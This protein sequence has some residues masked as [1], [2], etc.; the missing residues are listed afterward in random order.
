MI[1][2][3]KGTI[4]QRLKDSVVLAVQNLSYEVFLPRTVSERID[5]SLQ[6]NGEI[7]FITYHYLQVD[8]SRSVPVL[9]GF[10]NSYEKDFF[11]LFITVS[12][13]GPKAAIRAL[14]KPISQ[15]AT[16]INEGD[17]AFLKSLPGIGPQ[18]ARQIVAQLQGKMARFGLINDKPVQ[19]LSGE[20]GIHRALKEE[21]VEV[22]RRLQ[23]K[24]P[25]ALAMI[26]RALKENP[27]VD[28]IELLLNEIYTQKTHGTVRA[29]SIN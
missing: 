4:S 10:L 6:E 23:Y 16:A 9:I 26:E 5:G 25:E 17:F 20:P 7:E 18:R 28:S 29:E 19:S 15:I 2:S 21:A 14:D 12:G 1:A 13:I 11:E 8:Q 22:L 24:R 3:I 27:Q